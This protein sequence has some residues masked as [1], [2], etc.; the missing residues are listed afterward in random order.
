MSF[1]LEILASTLGARVTGLDI[2][3]ALDEPIIEMIKS[4]WSEHGVLVFSGQSL[5]DE[6]HARFASYFGELQSFEPGHTLEK[7]VPEI[8]RSANVGLDGSLNAA[9]DDQNRLLRLNWLWHADSTYRKR[10]TQGTVLRVVE[11]PHGGG[12][13]VFANMRAAYQA[14]SQPMQERIS[15]LA[16][17]HSFAFMVRSQGLPPLEDEELSSFAAVEHSLVSTLAGNKRSLFISPPYMERIVGWDRAQSHS[18]VSELLEWSTQPRF[19]YT[20][21][22]RDGDVVM[23][24]NRWTLHKVTPYDIGRNRRVMHGA[25]L[26]GKE[27]VTAVSALT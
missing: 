27:P 9:D 16:A 3:S 5:T 26:L 12:D 22:W 25:V 4:A 10:P 14:L 20:H 21:R 2:S 24:D 18:L 11:S 17:V 8:Y 1:H 19:L 6:S 15:T 7:C 13:T 23:W